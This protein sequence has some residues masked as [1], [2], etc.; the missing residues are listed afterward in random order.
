[1]NTNLME[2]SILSTLL[3][4]S[5]INPPKKVMNLLQQKKP[6]IANFIKKLQVVIETVGIPE[7][8]EP[9]E[10][11]GRRIP[12]DVKKIFIMAMQF[13]ILNKNGKNVK[14]SLLQQKVLTLKKL[15]NLFQ[16]CLQMLR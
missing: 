15:K 1:M 13:Y 4:Q 8:P 2:L 7:N 14:T 3:K 6:E 11:I 16:N 9:V 12:E 5:G 10:K